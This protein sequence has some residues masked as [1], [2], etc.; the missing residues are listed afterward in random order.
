VASTVTTSSYANAHAGALARGILTLAS[1]YA[2]SGTWL[3]LPS[4]LHRTDG[5][6]RRVV[7]S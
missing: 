7:Y 5:A 1:S 2:E 4:V 3:P 6:Q